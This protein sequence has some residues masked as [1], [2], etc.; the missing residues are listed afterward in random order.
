MNGNR[1]VADL[2][3]ISL[4][5]Q[6]VIHWGLEKCSAEPSKYANVQSNRIRRLNDSRAVCLDCGVQQITI[7]ID[8]TNA[9]RLLFDQHSGLPALFLRDQGLQTNDTSSN[10]IR[11]A[12]FNVGI[13]TDLVSDRW[14]INHLVGL[15]GSSYRAQ[16]TRPLGSTSLTTHLVPNEKSVQQR[17]PARIRS[18]I[19]KI[20][21]KDVA[22]STLLILCVSHIFPA[23]VRVPSENRSQRRFRSKQR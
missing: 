8:S 6:P 22:S 1:S 15:Y 11:N 23:S 7:E 16:S 9:T 12:L 4:R 14:F 13:N 19:R 3:P 21:N 5:S 17:N 2:H 20:L 10:A 18:S